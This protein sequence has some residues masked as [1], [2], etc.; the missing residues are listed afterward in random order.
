MAQ[1]RSTKIISMIKWIRTS[2]LSIKNSLSTRFATEGFPREQPLPDPQTPNSTPHTPH[3]GLR[4]FQQKS[5]RLTQLNSGPHVVQIW[6]RYVKT[7]DP[8]RPMKS[9]VETHDLHTRLVSRRKLVQQRKC[10]RVSPRSYAPHPNPYSQNRT[11]VALNPNPYP[12]SRTRFASHGNLV[13]V[14]P[15]TL[16]PTPCTL[17]PNP[18]TPH[19]AQISST[20][21]ASHGNAG[22]L[23]TPLAFPEILDPTPRPSSKTP[24]PRRCGP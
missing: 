18:Q 16:H 4:P 19:Q 10:R 7:F 3:S 13:S 1:G 8:T 23:K 15:S 11:F 22:L 17:H 21:F 20:R 24:Y 9:R 14:R 12:P 6:S 2:R 5:T